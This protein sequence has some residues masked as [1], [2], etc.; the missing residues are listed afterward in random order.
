M[1]QFLLNITIMIKGN[2][3]SNLIISNI[4]ISAIFSYEYANLFSLFTSDQLKLFAKNLYECLCKYSKH[5]V[6][7][8]FIFPI[9]IGMILNHSILQ[10][11]IDHISNNNITSNT[12]KRLVTTMGF[13][14]PEELVIISTIL[15]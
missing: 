2:D 5:S 9:S 12:D 14:I 10:E 4:K 13:A 11:A 1:T 15:E 6:N 8:F 3:M 7:I